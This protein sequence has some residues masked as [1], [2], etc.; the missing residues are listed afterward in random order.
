[1]PA[2]LGARWAGSSLERQQLV[3][4]RAGRVARGAAAAGPGSTWSGSS[5]RESSPS[6]SSL[7]GSTWSGNSWSGD[8]VEWPGAWGLCK[9]STWVRN[10]AVDT[11]T[12]LR[13]EA[14]T[15]ARRLLLGLGP[16]RVWLFIVAI[17]AVSARR[18]G[19]A[20]LGPAGSRSPVK[21]GS[22]SAWWE[23][24]PPSTSPRSSPST[25]ISAS[26]RTRSR[27]R[28][29][30]SPRALLRSPATSWPPRSSAPGR[31]AVHRR[32][33]RSSSPSTSLSCRSAPGSR[34]SSSVGR[35]R[36]RP[37][38]A[39][40]GDA[41]RGGA[42][43]VLGVVLVSAVIAVAEKRL[44]APAAA[45]DARD[46]AGRL[47][48][49]GLPR[50][51]WRRAHGQP[52]PWRGLLLVAPVLACGF[53]FR[54]YMAQREQREHVEFLYES[55]R[56]TQGA[57]EFGP[58]RSASCSSS[59]R[60]LLR[61]EYAEI[62][63][64][65]PAPPASPS[66]G[67]SSGAAGETP[68]AVRRRSAPEPTAL[69]S[70]RA[71]TSARVLGRAARAAPLD[72]SSRDAGSATR[73]SARS[74][75]RSG[76]F[77]LLIVGDRAGDVTTFAETDLELFETFAGHA[78][79]LLENGRLE[80]SLAQVTQLQ[81]GAAP[82]GLPRCAHR[83]AQSRALRRSTGRDARGRAP[84]REAHRRPLPRPRPLQERQRQ[85]G[86]A[87]GDELLVRSPRGSAARSARATS[88]ARLG[89]DE[90]AL[91]L[92]DTDAAG[93]EHAAQRIGDALN[94]TFSLAGK[95]AT[96]TRASASR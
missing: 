21:A 84:A 38:R 52:L 24:A 68:H 60:R 88:P 40:G 76:R 87:A 50:A 61:A 71:S 32:Q 92:V 94:A 66:C 45:A 74:A 70:G 27:C 65:S 19:F 42:A 41:A 95:E 63:L 77:G 80:Q 49:D 34:C 90:F 10:A 11:P 8:C 28:R 7:S 62:L 72:A 22:R 54:G 39:L 56:A 3:R 96:S 29:S 51:R 5:W 35:A 1:M 25:S 55:M 15:V 86:H 33:R 69:R 43:H 30:A 6:G 37:D 48:R 46:L 78:S 18:A 59:A 83:A 9:V 75:A 79:V 16:L 14:K 36:E 73:S 89:G 64:L 17:A 57:P 47:A 58:R 20:N 2:G 82:P 67:A 91:L 26:R 31:L 23:L 85:L 4:A 13:P 93:A 81:G 53:A 44:S 12:K